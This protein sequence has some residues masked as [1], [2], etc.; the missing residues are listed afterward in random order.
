[1]IRKTMVGGGIL[2][3]AILFFSQTGVASEASGGIVFP[4][5]A[6]TDEVV[7]CTGTVYVKDVE[8][9]TWTE[10]EFT[11]TGEESYGGDAKAIKVEPDLDLTLKLQASFER[12]NGCSIHLGGWRTSGSASI[13]GSVSGLKVEEEY[14]EH[15]G[16]GSYS[17]SSSVPYVTMWGEVFYSYSYSDIYDYT[18]ES[19]IDWDYDPDA[20]S[21]KYDASRDFSLG[22]YY[23]VFDTPAKCCGLQLLGGIRFGN[24]SF[25]DTQHVNGEFEKDNIGLIEYTG[26]PENPENWDWWEEEYYYNNYDLKLTSSVDTSGIG[27]LVGVAGRCKLTKKINVGIEASRSYILGAVNREALFVDIDDIEST[28]Y[29]NYYGEEYTG[30]GTDYMKGEISF[31]RNCT[32]I[33]PVTEGHIDLRYQLTDNLILS[34]GY[35]YSLWQDVPVPAQFQYLRVTLEEEEIPN[36]EDFWIPNLK[37]DI[38]VSGPK[39]ELAWRF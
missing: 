8:E 9:V 34:I 39:L 10:T 22:T 11:F 19:Y 6:G 18:T 2:L 21:T 32:A 36:V 1:V 27:P 28:Y 16:G 25:D 24:V 3:V 29:E 31:E 37:K 30:E 4:D 7:G 17:Y 26:D 38:L 23:L 12:E 13:S 15:E 20:V 5:A 35:F 33:I 14:E